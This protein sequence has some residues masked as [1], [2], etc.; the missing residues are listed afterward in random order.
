MYNLV[1]CM[2]KLSQFLFCF[3]E[4]RNFNLQA[5]NKPIEPPKKP[6]KASF[7]LPSIPSLSGEILFKPSKSAEDEKDA[8]DDDEIETNIK[9]DT[10]PTHFVNLIQSS[11]ETKNYN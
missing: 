5:H 6:E 1:S 8:K 3:L 11:A 7:S 4:T 2:L 10:P 9:L